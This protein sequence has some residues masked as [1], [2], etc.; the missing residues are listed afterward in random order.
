[1]HLIVHALFDD[2]VYYYRICISLALLRLHRILVAYRYEHIQV[3]SSTMRGCADEV[4]DE[5]CIWIIFSLYPVFKMP[6]DLQDFQTATTDG[7]G[8]LVL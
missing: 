4:T 7:Q 1:M 3:R 5:S 6:K 8:M 2:I